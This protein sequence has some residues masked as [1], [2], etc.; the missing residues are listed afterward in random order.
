MFA[1]VYRWKL[2]PGKEHDFQRAWAALTDE[3]IESH[4]GLG[5]RLH[6]G[7]EGLWL[8]Y[9]RWNDRQSWE[10]EKEIQNQEALSTMKQCISE[11]FPPLPLDITEDKLV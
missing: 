10:R 2:K 3:F 7:D 8:A 6:R 4:G 5:S 9:A 1:V 11:R